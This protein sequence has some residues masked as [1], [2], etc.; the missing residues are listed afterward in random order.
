MNYKITFWSGISSILS[1]ASTLLTLKYVNARRYETES[2]MR[3]K[4]ESHYCLEVMNHIV[5]GSNERALREIQ[6]VLD[7]DILFLDSFIGS[8][9]IHEVEARKVLKILS[10]QRKAINYTSGSQAKE[11]MIRDVL[12]KVGG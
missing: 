3:I 11:K 12:Q 7:A 4:L 5:T 9:S 1:I 2:L 8:G 6:Q 10:D